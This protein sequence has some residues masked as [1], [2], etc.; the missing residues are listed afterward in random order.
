MPSNIT[1]PIQFMQ[2]CAEWIVGNQLFPDAWRKLM[3]HC[4][5]VLADA[6]QDIHK[7]I[8]EIDVIH[9]PFTVVAATL[10]GKG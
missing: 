7:V 4:S 5:Q 1:R 3:H 6:L 10:P 9:E 2:I 8:I